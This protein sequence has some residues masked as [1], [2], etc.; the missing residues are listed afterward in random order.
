MSKEEC[1][2]LDVIKHGINIDKNISISHK[3]FEDLV[4]EDG[5]VFREKNDYNVHQGVPSK[6]IATN[7]AFSVQVMHALLRSFDY[8]MKTAVHVKAAVFD[9]SESPLSHN[10]R[11][12]T[13][14]KK[15]LQEKIAVETGLQWD[16]PDKTGRGGTT[17]TGN[18]ALALLLR[19]YHFRFARKLPDYISLLWSTFICH[20][21]GNVF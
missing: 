10:S 12:L 9:W 20:Y 7:Q 13:N 21:Q 16:I 19:R 15:S 2:N 17:T 3:I 1:H 4:Q 11:F 14:A 5:S 6:S 18:T 8:F